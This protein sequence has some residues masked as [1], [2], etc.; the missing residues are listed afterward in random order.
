MG[1]SHL[2]LRIWGACPC[3]EG[4]KSWECCPGLHVPTLHLELSQE[5]LLPIRLA[6]L[7]FPG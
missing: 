3:H 6:L 4:R 2:C 5:G 1:A 7:P